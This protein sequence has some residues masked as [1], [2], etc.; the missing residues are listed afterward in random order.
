MP[1]GLVLPCSHAWTVCGAVLAS[2]ANTRWLTRSFFT[3][4][5]LIRRA[6]IGYETVGFAAELVVEFDLDSPPA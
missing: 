2:R 6:D 5:R 3:L 1:D 4:K